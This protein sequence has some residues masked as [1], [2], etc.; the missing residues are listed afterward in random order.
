MASATSGLRQFR[1]G[2]SGRNVCRYHCADASSKVHADVA[3][4]SDGGA[5]HVGRSWPSASRSQRC[6]PV[7]VARQFVGG[8]PSGLPSRHQYQSRFGSSRPDREATN[9]GCS[10]LVWL[11]TWSMTTRRSRSCA[12]ATRASK[13]SIVP[14]TGSTS[15]RSATS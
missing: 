10:M 4:P 7:N 3:A 14:K 11:G 1:S 15:H 5:T 6:S 13:S 12:A 8:P 9:H 2:C